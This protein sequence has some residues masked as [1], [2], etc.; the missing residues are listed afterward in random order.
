MK[1]LVAI[2][3]AFLVFVLLM[4]SVT[5]GSAADI[6]LIVRAKGTKANGK[7]AHF[8]LIVNN[9]DC[10]GK[11]SASSCKE[12]CFSVPF[13]THEIKRIEVVFDNDYYSIGEDR[14][15]F[16]N[17]IYINNELPIKANKKNG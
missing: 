16:V 4:T 17:C 2:K 7:Y 11:Y 6:E 10:G 3:S 13:A 12:Y 1:N 14:N 5:I 8:R 15:L 9:L